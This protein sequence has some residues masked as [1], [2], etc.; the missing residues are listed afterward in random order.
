MKIYLDTCS[1]QRPLD[2]RNQVRVMTSGRAGGLKTGNRS[3]RLLIHGPPKGGTYSMRFNWSIRWSS[4]SWVLIYSR[5]TASSL[6]TLETKNPR[7]QGGPLTMSPS[8]P[9]TYKTSPF[10]GTSVST[11][12]LRSHNVWVKLST[13]SIETP[14]SVN[15]ERFTAGRV[16]YFPGN[17]K[18]L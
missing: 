12:Y 6:P 13:S 2:S 9:A 7:A 17:V 3:K 18:L 15:F 10:S 11:W 16:S 1:L 4:F 8:A 14:L 5:I